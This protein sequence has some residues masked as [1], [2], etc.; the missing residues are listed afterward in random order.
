MAVRKRKTPKDLP[1][2]RICRR[3]H[4]LTDYVHKELRRYGFLHSLF[5]LINFELRQQILGPQS[6]GNCF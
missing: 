1:L 3:Y 2:V 6:T 4:K 5:F